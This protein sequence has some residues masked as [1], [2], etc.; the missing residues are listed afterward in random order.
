MQN[1]CNR[2]LYQGDGGF[3]FLAVPDPQRAKFCRAVREAADRIHQSIQALARSRAG[4]DHRNTQPGCK[5]IQINADFFLLCFVHQIDAQHDMIGNLHGLKH[6]IQIPFQTGGVSN[7]HYGVGPAE[8]NEVPGNF[9]LGRVRH[10]RIGPRNIHH[11]KIGSSM[12][13][14]PLRVYDSF[15]RPVARMLVE[16]REAVEHRAFPHIRIAGKGDD[17][18]LLCFF[19]NM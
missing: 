4:T 13:V 6:Q 19:F 16:S 8:T 5:Q 10:Q 14:S 9:L 1:V 12:P 7:D 2:G 17:L 11:D 15:S 3:D 18:I